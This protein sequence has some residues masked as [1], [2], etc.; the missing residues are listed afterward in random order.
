MWEVVAA[1]PGNVNRSCDFEDLHLV[2]FL[3]AGITVGQTL[4]EHQRHPQGLGKLVLEMVRNSKS[5]CQSNANLGIALLFGPL[6]NAAIHLLQTQSAVASPDHLQ[7]ACQE[8]ISNAEVADTRLI[9]QAINLAQPGGMG[10]VSESDLAD[11]GSLSVFD[12]P[13]AVMKRAAERDL[14]A[15][16]YAT[17][18]STTFQQT[19]PQLLQFQAMG[20]P[21]QWS[22]IGTTIFLLGQA[23]DSLIHRKLGSEAA[24]SVQNQALQVG[25]GWWGRSLPDW[26]EFRENFW[27]SI[28]DD[29]ADFD[30]H[31][32]SDGHRRNPGTT[33]DLIAAGLFAGLVSGAISPS[34][35]W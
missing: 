8:V 24:K 22:I 34:S 11:A 33:A 14:I 19:L 28:S 17:G 5:V 16:E 4:A 12:T 15:L 32:R 20:Y 9:Y 10:K 31:L 23:P 30:F 1:K 18:F 3:S 26:N 29:L 2:D 13:E 27:Q 6:G 35:R 21:L 7:Q 25:N